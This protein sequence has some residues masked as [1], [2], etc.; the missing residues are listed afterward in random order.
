MLLSPGTRQSL[1]RE[2][3]ATG[4]QVKEA[5]FYCLISLPDGRQAVICGNKYIHK[6]A[7]GNR[8]VV[9][10][11]GKAL[12]ILGIMVQ[13][14]IT[15]RSWAILYSPRRDSLDTCSSTLRSKKKHQNDASFIIC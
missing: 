14:G 3:I 2:H 6:G 4:K 1:P 11:R 10:V 8:R 7:P 13:L 15:C 5:P 12:E 9:G